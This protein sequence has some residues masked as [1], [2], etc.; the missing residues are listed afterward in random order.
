MRVSLNGQQ[1]VGNA[2]V[3]FV[4]HA[5]PSVSSI[6]PSSGAMV[7]GTLVNVSGVGFESGSHYV[8]RFGS[9]IVGAAWVPSY[10]VISCFAPAGSSG[11]SVVV[12][13]SLNAQQ[14]SRGGQTFAY[15]GL[16]SVSAYSP[17]SG[18]SD[19]G[20]RVVVSGEGFEGGSDYRCRFDGCGECAT[21][22]SCGSCVVNATYVAN[23]AGSLSLGS[24]VCVSPRLSDWRFND[25]QA[26]VSLEVS[27]NSQQYTS[28][29]GT[30]FSYY[31]T[32]VLEAV[33]PSLGPVLG[34]TRVVINGTA[35]NGAA[36]H[37]LCK[38]NGN[39]VPGTFDAAASSGTGGVLCSSAVVAIT[40]GVTIV[41][42]AEDQVPL[43]VTLNG[44]QYTPASSLFFDYY[45]TLR[46]SELRPAAGPVDGGTTIQVHGY[47]FTGG[48][49]SNP[50]YLC[51]FPSPL[52][53][54]SAVLATVA[55][56]GPVLQCTSPARN[57]SSL[58]LEVTINGQN[59]TADGV[60]F[61][62]FRPSVWPAPA[63]WLAPPRSPASSSRL[64]LRAWW[65]LRSQ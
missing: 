9:V 43:Q 19:G 55:N 46:I 1:F 13:V 27:L 57:A 47:G 64:G 16:P 63:A 17:S 31:A 61:D 50:H 54:V 15:H 52:T 60:F 59:Y 8:C 11:S 22:W 18:P 58:E 3:P 4:Y 29:I 24:L 53:L 33:S 39:V 23:E 21:A 42:T 40:V 49:G 51:R 65:L 7:G 25:S 30:N 20:T 5:S 62:G 6:S 37:L 10:G 28:S 38:F 56:S 2:S 12:E 34:Q 26:S 45:R 41:I 48:V 32:P 44:Q 36:S 14:Y 35:L